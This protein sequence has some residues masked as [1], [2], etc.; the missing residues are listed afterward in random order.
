MDK[1]LLDLSYTNVIA[2]ASGIIGKRSVEMGSTVQPGQ[3][4]FTI[5]QIADIWVTANFK[6]TQLQR[7][8]PGQKAKIHVDAFDQDFN[9]YVE[10]MPGRVGIDYQPAAAGERHGQFREGGAASAG[11][12][13]FRQE[14]DGPRPAAAGHVRRAESVFAINEAPLNGPGSLDAEI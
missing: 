14:P 3:Q 1:A 13:P 10:S 8:R 2:P 7:M 12:S 6:E 11:A 9:G 5:A 4:L